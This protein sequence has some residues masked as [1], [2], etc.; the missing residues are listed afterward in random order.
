MQGLVLKTTGSWFI[1]E[2]ENKT[3]SC[4]VRGQLRLKDIV[5]TN[6]IAAGDHVELEEQ[7]YGTGVI[8][9]ILPRRNYIIRK[10]VN[11]SKQTHIIAA[12]IDRLWLVVTP[13]LPKT[14]TGFIDRVIAAAESF[15]IPVS[16]LFNKSDLFKDELAELQADYMSIYEPLG[17]QCLPVSAITGENIDEFRALVTGKVNLLAGHSGVGKSSVI[18]ALDPA[19]N[20]KV[21]SISKQHLKGKHTTTFA[22]MHKLA[23]GGYLID[24]PGIR[25]FVN[26][27]FKPAEI[28]HYFIEMRALI[29]ECKFHNCVHE[30]EKGC[31]VKAA[32]EAGEIHPMR[33]YNYLSMLRHEDIY[34]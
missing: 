23:S 11:L 20:L 12:N 32:V 15:H 25:E 31:A 14:S 5:S 26:I 28:G 3:I 1:V 7:Q 18:N 34:R 6:P 22:E 16:L 24:T 33:Y 13:E 19:V 2:T 30:N 4:R 29:H 21:N 8:T 9:D 10:S 17:Y 27:D